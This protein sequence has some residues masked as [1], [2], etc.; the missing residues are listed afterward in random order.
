MRRR[1]KISS[2]HFEI[3]VG[4][5]RKDT[6]PGLETRVAVEMVWRDMANGNADRY[7]REEWL[8]YIAQRVV[9]DVIDIADEKGKGSAALSALGLLGRRV[10]NADLLNALQSLHDFADLMVPDREMSLA[11]KVRCLKPGGYFNG[12][13]DNAAKKKIQNLL[14]N[15]LSQ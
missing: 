12:M 2:L 5:N 11:E 15:R 7:D 8:S 4:R 9:S 14:R 6:R 3:A 10:D 1:D 13:T